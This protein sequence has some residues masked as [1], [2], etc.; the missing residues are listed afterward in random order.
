MILSRRSVV[1]AFCNTPA[2]LRLRPHLSSYQ[3]FDASLQTSQSSQHN[4]LFDRAVSP[5]RLYGSDGNNS[6][7]NITAISDDIVD[8]AAIETT[9]SNEDEEDATEQE[10]AWQ[11]NPRARW[12]TRKHR[13]QQMKRESEQQSGGLDWEQFDF[14]ERLVHCFLY[15]ILITIIVVTY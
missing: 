3:H 14:G 15:C 6:P 10:K 12:S 7:R 4:I 2:T 9:E 1:S 8:V 13:K 5:T 11:Q